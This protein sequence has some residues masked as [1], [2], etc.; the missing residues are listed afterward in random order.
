MRIVL[1][2]LVIFPRTF[3]SGPSGKY[4][5]IIAYPRKTASDAIW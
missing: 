3:E 1:T 5:R 4:K 2:V